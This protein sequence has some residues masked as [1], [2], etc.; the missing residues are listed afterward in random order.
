VR[1]IQWCGNKLPKCKFWRKGWNCSEFLFNCMWNLPTNVLDLYFILW[2]FCVNFFYSF[3]VE[4]PEV[5]FVR[6]KL[7]VKAFVSVGCSELACHPQ[8]KMK[9]TFST[10]KEINIRKWIKNQSLVAVINS[11]WTS[12]SWIIMPWLGYHTQMG[13]H[14]RGNKQKR[15]WNRNAMEWDERVKQE[16]IERLLKKW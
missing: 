14:T 13:I 8:W 5:S 15:K 10:Q 11:L 4:N 16:Q 7:K 3:A 1:I 9:I 6:C 12:K 2:I